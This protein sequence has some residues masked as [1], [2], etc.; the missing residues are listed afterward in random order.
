VVLFGFTALARA[1]LFEDAFITFRTVEHFV[2]GYGLRW[3]VSER[4]QSYTHPL[5]MLLH[6]PLTWVP[7]E[8]YYASIAVSLL[9]SV[10][11]VALAL[12]TWHRQ[13]PLAVTLALAVPLTLTQ[14]CTLYATS[15]F[16][17]PL[18]FF[19]LVLY[20]RFLTQKTETIPWF[21][22]SLVCALA[23]LNRLDNL[24][25]FLPALGFLVLRHRQQL[26]WLRLFCGQVPLALWHLFSLF[27]YGF[28]FP[29][30]KYA[31]LNTG[32]SALDSLRQGGLYA[33]DLVRKDLPAA[34]LLIAGVVAVAIFAHRLLGSRARADGFQRELHGRL[35]MVGLGL[36]LYCAYILRIGGDHS[37][38]RQWAT[39]TFAATLLATLCALGRAQ[40]QDRLRGALVLLFLS[41]ILTSL[42]A[43]R[44][45]HWKMAGLNGHDK[46]TGIHY[47][48][49][50]YHLLHLRSNLTVFQVPDTSFALPG[51]RVRELSRN[52]DGPT[53]RVNG[54]VGIRGYYSGPK[55]HIIDPLGLCDP[56]LARLPVPAGIPW[57]IGHFWRDCPKGY[58]AYHKTGKM[59]GMDPQLV[60]YY[61]PLHFII[62]GPLFSW[63]RIKTILAFNL[64]RY[65]AF[66]E[67]YLQR[68]PEVQA[69]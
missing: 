14:T 2:E 62:T 66:L 18:T 6:V 58:V 3:N 38:F 40:I 46:A 64:G 36:V 39:P 19:L 51:L 59:T 34:G 45:E 31:K 54:A 60:Q 23:G 55:A 32:I 67:D 53:V 50:E 68:Y 56:L 21:R 11:A 4:V 30:T 1:W 16:E 33:W 47:Q 29:N 20:L 35:L 12:F 26:G 43:T 28:L 15:G 48:Y 8:L 13:S 65:D 25:L 9:F 44:W 61:E 22:L 5:W 24:V 42:Q 37:S 17:N 52:S 69:D 41:L 57:R 27:Y 10:G 7:G 49:R 63:D